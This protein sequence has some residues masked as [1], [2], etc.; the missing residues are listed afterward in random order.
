[1]RLAAEDILIAGRDHATR[2]RPSLRAAYILQRKYGLQ[3]LYQGVATGHF[4]I[5][6]DI[7]K[8]TAD[9]AE[10]AVRVF[11]HQVTS[12]GL[13]SL[14]KLADP[15]YAVL[16]ASYGIDDEIKHPIEAKDRPD[17]LFDMER[18][19]VDLY[20]FGTGWLNWTPTQTWNAIPAEIMA[21]QR[22]FIAKHNAIHGSAEDED[23]LSHDPREELTPEQLQ[24][25]IAKLRS[26]AAQGGSR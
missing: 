19:L 4:G 16:S 13:A 8:N 12:E 11:D 9:D 5:V 15:L 24:A 23:Q 10:A 21:A 7:L 20:E 17:Q 25:N 14:H 1:M 18:A 2:L 6:L 22:G 3:R 26:I